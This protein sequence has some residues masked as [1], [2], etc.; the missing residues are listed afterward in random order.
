VSKG[1][2]GRGESLQVLQAKQLA[3]YLRQSH[4][5]QLKTMCE[6]GVTCKSSPHVDVYSVVLG[7]S[8]DDAFRR[9]AAKNQNQFSH[10]HWSKQSTRRTQRQSAPRERQHSNFKVPTNLSRVKITLHR[11]IIFRSLYT[12]E[13]FM[14]KKVTKKVHFDYFLLSF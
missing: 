3:R 10:C 13:I 11:I 14:R 9:L 4:V 6:S 8:L 2:C 7:A 1:C 5:R 12:K